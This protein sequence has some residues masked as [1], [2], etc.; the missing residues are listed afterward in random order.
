M[1][2][3]KLA[4]Y[5]KPGNN[6]NVRKDIDSAVQNEPIIVT[7]TSQD[8]ESVTIE[9]GKPFHPSDASATSATPERSFSTLRQLSHLAEREPRYC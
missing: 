4:G 7:T 9:K 2:K 5:F 3:R 6:K 8:K 1:S